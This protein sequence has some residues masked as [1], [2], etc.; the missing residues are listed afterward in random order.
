M[1]VSTFPLIQLWKDF[2]GF[3][4]NPSCSKL[5]NT[6]HLQFPTGDE[7]H[8]TGSILSLGFENI[9]GGVIM[10]H[11][12]EFRKNCMPRIKNGKWRGGGDEGGIVVE[13]KVKK[14]VKTKFLKEIY[15]TLKF[16]DKREYYDTYIGRVKK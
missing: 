8:N 1:L 7:G 12:H 14:L 10:Y 9:V 5:L 6:M 2:M 11:L 16:Q 15:S 13:D 4:V 3:D